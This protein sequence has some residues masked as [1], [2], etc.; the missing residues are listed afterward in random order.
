MS[1][2]AITDLSEVSTLPRLSSPQRR[3]LNRLYDDAPAIPITCAA[4]SGEVHFKFF[5]ETPIGIELPA[6]HRL[7]LG[8]YTGSLLID[9]VG[10]ASLIG[11][12]RADLL[13]HELR[14]VLLA[15]ALHAIVDA[16]KNA[17]RLRF[18]WLPDDGDVSVTHE[19]AVGF[20]LRATDGS[21]IG[22]GI[23]TLDEPKALD[24]I[25]PHFPR[26]HH[27]PTASFDK[28]LLPLRFEL[29]STQISL[30]EIR[31]IE[32]GDVVGIERW[33][34]SG[35]AL[36]VTAIVGGRGGLRLSG[37]ADESQITLTDI[38]ENAVNRDVTDTPQALRADESAGLPLGRLDAL[39]V[40]LRFEVGE[41]AVSLGELKSLSAGHVFELAEP[42]SRSAVRIL[43]HGHVLGKGYIVAV[44]DRLGVRVSEFVPGDL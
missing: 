22:R 21:I 1:H 41:L 38:G 14:T 9:N 37:L 29:G 18:E 7:R 24:A 33:A 23:A 10:L 39:E 4:V 15:D 31:Q 13:P 20:E 28:L 17:L 6:R 26:L 3:A 43:A 5:E 11:E 12:P 30:Q 8:P 40:T 25:V 27:K 44:G 2:T 34:A 32:A 16:L 35:A 36:H 42:L 19:A